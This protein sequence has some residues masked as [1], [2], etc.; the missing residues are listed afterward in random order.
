MYTLE[1]LSIKKS[2]KF[3]DNR[4]DI[5]ISE[6]NKIFKF[7]A[8]RIFFINGKKNKTRGKHAHKLCNQLLFHISGKIE[9]IISDGYKKRKF[10]LSKNGEYIL[11]PNK[12]WAEQK[13]LSINSRILVCCDKK[14]DKND[15]IYS[16]SNL[17][18]YKKNG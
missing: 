5:Y 17:I 18:E 12:F 13:F 16:I 2:T 8:E 10:T 4:G 15:Y 14:Y 9:I 7:K 11:L 1:E 6:L 3:S